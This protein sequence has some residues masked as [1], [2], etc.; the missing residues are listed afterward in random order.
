MESRNDRTLPFDIL[1][2]IFSQLH[3]EISWDDDHGKKD[4]LAISSVCRAIR[5]CRN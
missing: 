2:A 1:E 4:L 5:S 3:D